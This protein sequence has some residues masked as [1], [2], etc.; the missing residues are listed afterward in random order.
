V[1][2]YICAN[3][4][5]QLTFTDKQAQDERL[6]QNAS[7]R[8]LI[9]MITGICAFPIFEACATP[10][11]S[12]M[13]GAYLQG[14]ETITGFVD[15]VADKSRTPALRAGVLN[16]YSIALPLDWIEIPVSNARSGNY[17]QP[18]CDEVADYHDFLTIGLS[19][20]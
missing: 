16:P 4:S 7:R 14:S 6:V 1:Y 17:C 8:K 2:G 11:E 13:V 20:I 15:F 3:K 12:K 9:G 19:F 5:E 10:E 18:R